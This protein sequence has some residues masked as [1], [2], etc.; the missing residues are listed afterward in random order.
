MARLILSLLFL[1]YSCSDDSDSSSDPGFPEPSL[2]DEDFSRCTTTEFGINLT[3][4][5]T[6]TVTASGVPVTVTTDFA[7]FLENEVGVVN[8]NTSYSNLQ[9][10]PSFTQGTVQET[11]NGSVGT[12]KLYKVTDTEAEALTWVGTEKIDCEI[13]F[14]KQ[15][16]SNYTNGTSLVVSYSPAIPWA[17][18]PSAN[19]ATVD[20]FIGE[21]F[22]TEFTATVDYSTVA[23]VASGETVSGSVTLSGSE[24]VYTITHSFVGAEW[25]KTSLFRTITFTRPNSTL[26]GVELAVPILQG[27]NFINLDLN[28]EQ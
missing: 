21:G 22:T 28:A 18:Y 14:M 9:V 24:E 7:A 27:Q 1:L 10:T 15:Q 12:K 5:V 4:P 2:S 6:Q 19:S 16:I 17:V 11:L 25:D 26:T 13:V 3:G 8:L 20:S 23:G